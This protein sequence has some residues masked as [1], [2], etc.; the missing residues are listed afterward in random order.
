MYLGLSSRI[1]RL[2][3][4]GVKNELV[5]LVVGLPLWQYW[6]FGHNELARRCH[7]YSS[8]TLDFTIGNLG[9]NNKVTRALLF[10][11]RLPIVKSSV[12]EEEA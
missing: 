10:K 4:P 5:L 7:A 6:W 3:K 2:R 1:K 11:A 12:K 9:L 8:L